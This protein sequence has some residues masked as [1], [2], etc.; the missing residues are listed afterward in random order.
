MP[1]IR[2][3]SSNRYWINENL[4][5]IHVSGV[6]INLA[7]SIVEIIKS[8][9]NTRISSFNSF[10]NECQ[11]ILDMDNKDEASAIDFIQHL[12]KPHVDA[13]IFEIVSYAILKQHYAQKI[14]F[15]GWSPEYINE[16]HLTLFKTG[17]T[18]A[19]DGGIDFVMRPI[20]RFFQVTETV[21]AGKYFLDLDKLQQYPI[22]FVVKT[23]DSVDALNAKL[24]IQALEK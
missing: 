11:Q 1:I 12:L 18:N 14:I 2:D 21:D 20:G 15:W 7:S 5:K 6:Q 17:R 22:T 4:L 8:Y 16:E 13:R 3:V 23:E 24:R 9:V 10:I 19:N